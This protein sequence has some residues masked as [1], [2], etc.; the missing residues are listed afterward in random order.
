MELDIWNALPQV[1][2]FLCAIFH[3]Y[4]YEDTQGSQ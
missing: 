4:D 3:K 2:L 1:E